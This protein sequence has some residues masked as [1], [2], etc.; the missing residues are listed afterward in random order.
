[1]DAFSFPHKTRELQN[2]HFDSTVWNDFRFR[3]DDIVIST[4]GKSGTTWM[5][6][7]VGQLVFDGAENLPIH[8]MSPW[9]DLRV[10]PAHVKLDLMEAQKHRRFIKTHLP[11]DALVFSPVAKYIYIGRDGR[12]AVWSFYNHWVN[13]NDKFYAA[14]NDTPGRVG[15]PMPRCEKDVVSVFRDWLENDGEPFWSLWE[16]VRGWWS[17]RSLPNVLFVHYANLKRDL[18]GQMR[19][20]SRF[21]DI[22]ID[23]ERWPAIVE[24]CTFDYMKNNAALVTPLGGLLFEGGG[25]TF[26]NKGTN[27]RWREL[28]TPAD[29]TAYESR[30]LAELG[31]ECAHWL[32][33]GELP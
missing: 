10:P 6:Q 33:S 14:I 22:P 25:K 30:A 19:R 3:D 13:A 29:I 4:Y 23:Q 18:P 28:L 32:E 2:H 7:I 16:H 24:H 21:L 1:M 31:P 26:I 27:G 5:Q 15:P 20:I 17:V 12:D 11:V 8:E 9:L